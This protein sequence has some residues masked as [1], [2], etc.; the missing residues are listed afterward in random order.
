M[1]R[2]MKGKAAA[3]LF[4]GAVAWD[5]CAG[6]ASA[7]ELPTD[8]QMQ[9]AFGTAY[10]HLGLMEYCVGHGYAHAGDVANTRRMV[11]ATV[12][13]MDVSAAARGQQ[14]V[15][16]RGFV[17]GEQLVGRMDPGNPSHPEMVPAG[18]TMS[19]ADN[20]RA[21]KTSVRELCAQ[22]AA[23]VAPVR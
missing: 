19:L 20:A 12:A 23:Q 8:A 17:I 18:R 11:E 2:C 3:F 22:M 5:A 10:N 4:A 9:A 1:R 16:Q 13:G 15:G 21:Q 6:T 14:A 7:Q